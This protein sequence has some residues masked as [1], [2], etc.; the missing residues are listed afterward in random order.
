M[1]ASC[2]RAVQLRGRLRPAAPGEGPPRR[3]V[4][5]ACASGAGPP[6][7]P[8]LRACAAGPA[9]PPARSAHLF[10]ILPNSMSAVRLVGE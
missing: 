3:R 8:L 1:S 6:R 9:R 4:L 2:L 7:R 5:R 10:H